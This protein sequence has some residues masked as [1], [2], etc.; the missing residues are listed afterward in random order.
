LFRSDDDAAI[1]PSRAT[2]TTAANSE[3][4]ALTNDNEAFVAL[5]A[6]GT[7]QSS[8]VQQAVF[9][10]LIEGRADALVGFRLEPL[11]ISDPKVV[12]L[13]GAA[14][15][16]TAVRS[17]NPGDLISGVVYAITPAELA[18]ADRYEVDAVRIEAELASGAHAYIYVAE[19]EGLP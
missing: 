9:G 3:A 7:L 17:G 2:G 6:Y 19:I 4:P 11:A 8:Q 16:Q 12:E 1:L 15:H 14:I 13:S 10:R 5:F 18:T